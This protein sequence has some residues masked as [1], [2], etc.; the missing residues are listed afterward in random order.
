[1][2]RR[3]RNGNGNGHRPV[4]ARPEALPPYRIAISLAA[5]DSVET[6]FALDLAKL[7]GYSASTIVASKQ[8]MIRLNV[9]SSSLIACSRNDLAAE[10]LQTGCTHMLCIDSD[11]RFPKDALVRLLRHDKDI[12]GI[13]YSTRKVPPGYVAFKTKGVDGA[14]HVRC[15][16]TAESTGLEQ[17]DAIGFGLVCINLDVFR[18]LAYPA[19]DVTYDRDH[20][21]WVGE[22]VNFC[23]KAK[24]NGREVWVDHDLSKE[25]AHIGRMEY[26]LDHVWS[27]EDMDPGPITPEA[28]DESPLVVE[29]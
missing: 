11:M 1:M 13:N 14:P 25:C 5:M 24:A 16:T 7:V 9:L 20:K 22:D 26:K 28:R 12:V 4:L 29:V 2:S 15:K 21:E 19:F 6:L 10:A 8:A 23:L 27:T 18:G 3:H 17:V